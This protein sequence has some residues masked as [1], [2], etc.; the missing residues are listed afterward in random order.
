VWLMQHCWGVTPWKSRPKFVVD[1]LPEM[2]EEEP[3]RTV[4]AVRRALPALLRLQR[5]E[6]RAVAKRD[7]AI[8]EISLRECQKT[9][10]NL[11][12]GAQFFA[13][14]TQFSSRLART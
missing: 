11:R 8:R 14:R 9:Q 4:E 3:Q 13:K 6:A 2:P 10:Y 12:L 1:D 5:Y 7:H